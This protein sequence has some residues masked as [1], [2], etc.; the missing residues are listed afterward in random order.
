[1]TRLILILPL[2]TLLGACADGSKGERLQQ[3]SVI[4]DSICRQS[5]RTWSVDDTPQTVKDARAF[6]AA[7]AA[8]CSR[9]APTS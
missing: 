6:N 8:K 4:S 7:R 9:K 1:M 3:V 5:E 2:V